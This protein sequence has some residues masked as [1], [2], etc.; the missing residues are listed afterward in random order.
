MKKILVLAMMLCLF[1]LP[2]LAAD[3]LTVTIDTGASVTLKDSDNDGAYEIATADEL[4]AFAAAVNGGNVSIDGELTADITVNTNVLNDDDSLNGTPARVWTPIGSQTAIYRGQFHGSMHTISGL[5]FNDADANYAGLFGRI[6]SASVMYVTVEYS[7]FFGAMHVGGIVGNVTGGSGATVTG[8][9]SAA[10]VQGTKYVGGIVGSNYAAAIADCV[11]KGLV[12]APSETE[13]D[14]GYFGGITGFITNRSTL[15]NCVNQGKVYAPGAYTVGG[16]A[17]ETANYAS[18]TACY[19]SAP[20]TGYSYV[21]GVLGYGGN[22]ASITNCYN[23]APVMGFGCVGGVLGFGDD[24]VS[25]TNCYNSAPV[26]G[27]T[28]VGGITGCVRLHNSITNCYFNSTMYS[29]DAVGDKSPTLK[30]TNVEGKTDAQFASG[31]VAYL[32]NGDQ[33][34]IV[35]TQNIGSEKIPGFSGK[36]VYKGYGSCRD[37]GYTNAQN[38]SATKPAHT[39][40]YTAEGNVITSTCSVC[41]TAL[42]TATITAQNAVYTG[43]EHET[44]TVICSED[45]TS[46]ELTPAYKNNVNAGIATASISIE[47]V[48][49]KVDFSIAK[50]ASSVLTAPTAN[51]LTY[52]GEAQALVTAGTAANGTMVYSLDGTNWSADVPVGTAAKNYTVYYK[53]VGDDN[54]EDT[55]PRA[56]TVK[57]AKL[58]ASVLTAPTANDL[59][60][61]GEAQALVTSG[62]ASNGTMVY[63]LDGTNWSADVPMGTAAQNYTV[64][65]KV[66]GDD[67]HEDTAPC[68]VTVKIT[69]VKLPQTG[70]DSHIFLWLALATLSSVSMITLRKR[71]RG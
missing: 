48:T 41:E 20:V 1:A 3:D 17:G 37:E 56:V 42:G 27:N 29:G 31:E 65:Y 5:Y 67:N 46:G 7:W 71:M 24:N 63:S 40:G 59:T 36:Q 64:Y 22:K 55:A 9:T 61:I 69:A 53:V 49:A 54:Y 57:I 28:L 44:A 16:I 47:G 23:S 15:T 21:G 34:T 30:L 62:T 12:K 11:N 60:Y 6:Q 18:M 38:P 58:S 14:S 35:F 25:T 43:A 39:P 10:S 26:T 66:M 52:I 70:D 2:A 51:D 32:L 19:N 8:C 33:S 50:A 4:Y 68:A 13:M 45:W